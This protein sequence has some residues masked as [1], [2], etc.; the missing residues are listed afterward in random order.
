MKHGKCMAMLSMFRDIESEHFPA[1]ETRKVTTWKVL[2]FR[3]LKQRKW[4]LS[5][6]YNTESKTAIIFMKSQPTFTEFDGVPIH[7]KTETK[8]LM[9]QFL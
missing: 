3:V 4:L 1:F 5:T 7:E 2:T 9:L 8:N 6:L